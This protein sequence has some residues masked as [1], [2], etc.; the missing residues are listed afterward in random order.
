[1]LWVIYAAYLFIVIGFVAFAAQ[2]LDLPGMV[3]THAFAVGGAGLA[4]LGLMARVALGHTGRDVYQP[5]KWVSAMIGLLLAGTI[6]RVF[7]PLLTMHLYATAMV[8]A[9]FLWVSAFGLFLLV[10]TPILVTARPDG[11]PG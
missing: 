2:L 4:T 10:Y 3:A 9:Q 7:A 8:I 5:P 1:M 6:V 11:K